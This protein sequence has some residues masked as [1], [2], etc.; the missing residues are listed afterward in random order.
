MSD[1]R[2][3]LCLMV[4]DGVLYLNVSWVDHA[5]VSERGV[6]RNECVCARSCVLVRGRV[7][8]D[9]DVCTCE[10][11]PCLGTWSPSQ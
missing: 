3:C 4:S 9:A 2:M 6:H 10:L 7:C 8:V 5:I 1:V 11:V